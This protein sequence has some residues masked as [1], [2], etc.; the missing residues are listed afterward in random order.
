MAFVYH[1]DTPF[2]SLLVVLGSAFDS[3]LVPDVELH[4][5][6]IMLKP[7][8]KLVL[9]GCQRCDLSAGAMRIWQYVSDIL[10]IGQ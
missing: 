9:G 1:I 5:L 3:S 6:G 8:G 10:K 2:L 4:R 7:T